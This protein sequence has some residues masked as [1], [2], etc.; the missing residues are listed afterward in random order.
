MR[1]LPE[2]GNW[3]NSCGSYDDDVV[4]PSER[5]D[6]VAVF[7]TWVY[8][9]DKGNLEDPQSERVRDILAKFAITG[10]HDELWKY[11]RTVGADDDTD[12]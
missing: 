1:T 3:K 9:D 4:F 10:A 2:L 6:F 5:I 7:D 11:S 12:E 8:I